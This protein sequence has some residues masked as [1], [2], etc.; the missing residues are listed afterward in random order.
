M[1]ALAIAR[2]QFDI[3][4][5]AELSADGKFDWRQTKTQGTGTRTERGLSAQ[6]PGNSRRRH[7]GVPDRRQQNNSASWPHKGTVST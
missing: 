6:M 5:P 1:I 4:V 3:A 2:D 7:V